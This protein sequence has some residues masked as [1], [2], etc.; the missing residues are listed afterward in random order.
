MRI[1]A[2]ESRR[3]EEMRSLIER[4]GGEAII[5]P[6][7]REIPLEENQEVFDFTRRLLAE[8]FQLVIFLTGVGARTLLETAES[9]FS[10]EEILTALRLCR[11]A[12]RGPK[13]L[14][15]MR[16]WKVEVHT[17]APE[18]NTWRELMG[19]LEKNHE[20][21]HGK[22]V[23]LQEYGVPST[24]LHEALRKSGAELTTVSV[25]RW[26]LPEDLNPLR[27]AIRQI[28]VGETDCLMF[29]S[30]QQIQHVLMIAEAEEVREEFL[31]AAR[32]CLIASIGPTTT[33]TLKELGLG[34]DLEPEHPKMGHLVKVVMERG[35]A[36][37][38]LKK[39]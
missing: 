35:E 37:L 21:T 39:R 16:E 17:L 34:V 27:N 19:A 7:L 10:R 38:P 26:G 25:Y 20:L 5:A 22:R 29:T 1:C 31:N 14:A 24:E 18:P 6:S 36:L 3:G 32:K 13:P 28:I 8:D 33:E 30:A 12:V 23:A 15:V 9:Q 2:F 11:I 4:Q